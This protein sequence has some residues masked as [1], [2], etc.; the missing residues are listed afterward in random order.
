MPEPVSP[1][2]STE[3][4]SLAGEAVTRVIARNTFWNYTGYFVNLATSLV[5]FPFVVRQMGDAA[6][7]AWLL[8]ASVTGYMGLLE[9]GLVPAL[10]Q[11]VAAARGR[12]DHREINRL[13][14]TTLALLSALALI[15]L[16]LSTAA[17]AIA[18]VLDVP[19][20][21][22]RDAEW[23]VAIALAGFG[24]KMP[25]AT[26]QALLIGCQRQDR[27]NQLWILLAAIKF[28][29]TFALLWSGFGVVGV[30]AMEATVHLL[31]GLVQ[32]RWVYAELPGLQLSWRAVDATIAQSLVRFGLS[33]LA[34]GL[35]AL[36]IE[37]TDRLVIG[38]FLSIGEVTFYS[39]AWKIYKVAYALPTILLHAVG[40]VAA[41]LYGR[42][43]MPALR[44]LWLRMTRLSAAVSWPLVAC[45]SA[46]APLL[47]GLW[48]GPAYTRAA[49]VTVALLVALGVT[50]Y[51][52]AGYSTLVGMRQIKGLL[53]WYQAPQALLNVVLSVLLVRRFGIL[54]VAIGTMVPVLLME[55]FFLRDLF[56]RLDVRASSF[57]R[58]VVVPTAG[59]AL[60]A[61]APLLAARLVWGGESWLVLGVALACS[62]AYSVWFLA[63][64]LEPSERRALA[65]LAG[66]LVGVPRPQAPGQTEAALADRHT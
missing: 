59:R 23:V 39:A 10:V 38:A 17:P 40:P 8:V 12:G 61:F 15:P 29:L 26:F 11:F 65:T 57:V 21:L 19:L 9:L 33:L 46:C 14:S 55:P 48:V 1:P 53:W 28:V 3:S 43:D 2:G 49:P 47:L 27:A 31:A 30:V 24:L 42:G 7:G 35:C 44:A 4:N 52:H 36:A 51:N 5:L 16:A 45:L 62:V 50:A 66:R 25:Q 56:R 60:I 54:G 64:G 20:E 34:L 6:S 63:R 58:L 13:T 41:G 18:G 32:V 37:H 22:R